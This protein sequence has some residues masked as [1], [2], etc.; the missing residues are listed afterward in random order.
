MFLILEGEGALR[1][2]NREYG[3]KQHDV[4]ACPPGGQ[5]VAHQIINTSDNDIKYLCV[6]T[7]EPVDVC[8]YP[9]SQ[10]VMTMIGEQGNRCFRHISQLEH[11]VEYF[12][13]EE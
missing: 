1:F 12:C 10:K 11:S 5:E 9:D 8:E 4:I 6:S 13:D 3:I 2:G 7:N